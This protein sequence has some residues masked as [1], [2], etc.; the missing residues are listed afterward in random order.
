MSTFATIAAII[1]VATGTLTLLGGFW[2]LFR[3]V[4]ALEAKDREL[5]H[6]IEMLRLQVSGVDKGLENEID[7]VSLLANGVRERMEHINTRL[8][9]DFKAINSTLRALENWLV[10]NTSYERRDRGGE[11]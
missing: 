2:K 3:L 11:S 6:Q 10:K 8:V 4:S 9:G 1:G 7:K 5:E